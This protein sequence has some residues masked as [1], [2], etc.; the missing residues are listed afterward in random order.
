MSVQIY[1]NTIAIIGMA[2]RFPGNVYDA[3][4]L[5]DM[6]EHGRHGISHI[7]AERWPVDE[8][9]HPNRSEAGRSVTF[10]A[11]ALSNI[12]QFDASFFGISPREAAWLDPQQRLLLEMSYEAMEDAGVKPSSLAGSR[13][14]VY[15]GISALDYGQHALEDLASMSAYT[16]T[17]NTLSIA[18]NRLSYFFDLH[19]PSIAVDT[20]CSSS[21]VALHQA[22][23]ALRCGEVPVALAGGVNLLMH[24]YSFIGFSHASMLSAN[25]RCRPFDAA[26]DGYVRAEGGAMLLLKPLQQAQEDGDCIHAVILASGVNADGARKPGLTIPSTAAQA[27][28]M[29]DVLAR[30]GLDADDIAFIE[31][32]GTGT[33]VGDPIEAASIGLVYGQGRKSPMPISSVKANLGHMEPASGMAGLVKAI[34]T[35]QKGILPP[36]PLE[37]TPSPR[38]DFSGLNLACPASGMALHGKPGMLAA[39]VN[40]FGFGGVNAHVILR[41]ADSQPASSLDTTS[42]PPL[43]LSAHS[44]T[45]LRSLAAVYAAHLQTTGD[46]WYDIAHTAAFCRDR[47]EKRLIVHP[48]VSEDIVSTLRAFAE[49]KNSPSVQVESALPDESGIAFIYTGN[50]AQ[51][52][53]MGRN[54]HAESAVFKDVI[55]NLDQRMRPLLHFSLTDALLRDDVEDLADTT[56]SQPLLFAIQVGLTIL[57]REKGIR[58]QAVA[59]HSVG[60]IAAAWAAGA[61]T[62]D[63]AIQVIYARSYAQGQTRGGGR[64]AVASLSADAAQAL[65]QKKNL[66]GQLEIAGINAPNNVTLSGSPEA[67]LQ[68]AEYA[69]A[70]DVFFRQLDLDYAFHSSRMDAVHDV[71]LHKLEGLSPSRTTDAIF[72]SSVSGQALEGEALGSAYWWDNVRQPV[73]F[74]GAIEALAAF[75]FRIFVEIGPHAILQRYIRENLS[76]V[77]LK[78]RV[79]SSLLRG[80]DGAKRITQLA[81]RLH[82][83]TGKTD[84]HALFPHKGRRVRLPRY[85]WQKQRCWYPRTSE[86]QIDKRR[87]HPLLGWPLNG[88]GLSWENILDPAKDAWLNDHKVGEAVVFPGA[89]YVEVALAAARAWLGQKAALEYLDII[90]PLVLDGGQ[91]QS[92]RCSLNSDD[93]SISIVSRPRMGTGEWVQHARAR[94]IAL[95]QGQSPLPGCLLPQ[96]CKIPEDCREMTGADLYALT[97]QLGLDYGPTF[98]VVQHIRT[99]GSRLEA[100]VLPVEEQGYILPPALLDACFHS[101]AALYGKEQSAFLPIR[102]GRIE[103]HSS[104]SIS[105]IQGSVRRSGKRALSANFE[106]LD[107]DGNLVVRAYDCRFRAVPLA[108]AGKNSAESW[109]ICPWLVPMQDNESA[110]I[111]SLDALSEIAAQSTVPS[112]QREVWYKQILPLMEAMTLSAAVRAFQTLTDSSLPESCQTTPYFR[113]LHGL[114]R[115]EGVLSLHDGAWILS[116]KNTPPSLEE[117]WRE[118][119]QLA[120]QS[121][122]ALLPLGR[123]CRSLP[124]VL[125][126]KVDGKTLLEEIRHATVAGENRYL[127]SNWLGVDAALRGIMRHLAQSWPA[128]RRLRVLEVADYAADLPETLEEQLSPDRFDYALALPDAALS[129]AKARY[130]QHPAVSLMFLDAAQWHWAGQI[131]QQFDVVI[132]RHSLHKAH[133]CAGAL[134]QISDLLS[135]G[136]L[137]LLAERHPDWSTD[138]LEGLEP[139]WWRPALEDRPDQPVSSLLP[140][141]AWQHILASRGFADCRMWR[142]PAAGDLEE[143]AYLV[144]ARQT[145]MPAVA[146]VSSPSET[147][148]MCW[149]LLADEH[150]AALAEELRVRLEARGQSVRIAGEPDS[151]PAGETDHVVFMRGHEVSPLEVSAELESLRKCAVRCAESEPAPRL[152][153]MTRGGA[154]TTRLPEGYAPRPAQ[155]AMAGMARVVMNEYEALRCTLLDVPAPETSPDLPARLEQEFLRPDGNDEILLTPQA[156]YALRLQA[157]RKSPDMRPM[158]RCHLDFAVPGRLGNLRWQP[159]ATRPLAPGEIEARVTATGLNFRDV[160]LTMGL[161][162]DDAVENG[163]A[164]ANLGLEFAGIVT[165]TGAEADSVHIG[166]RIIGFAPAC[167]ASH[168]VTSAHTVARIPESWSDEAAA[169]IPTVFF[170]AW[171]ALKHLAQ[172]QSGES[173]LVHGAAGGVG[174][175]AIQIARFLGV[176]ILATAGSREKRDFLHLL[177]VEHVFDSRSLSF[178]DDVL[179]AT[180]GQG[181]DAVLNSLA[182]E[183]M[184]RSLGLLKPFGRFLE[185]GKRDFVEN[186]AMGLRPLKENISYFAI[187]V[188]QLLTAR[189]ETA[190][191][192]FQEVMRLLHAEVLRPLPYRA[193]TASRVVSA[194]RTMQQAQHMGKIVVTQEDLSAETPTSDDAKATDFSGAWLV[195]GGLSGFGL[196]TARHLA[197]CGVKHLVLAGRRGADTPEAREI[198]EYFR[199][200]DVHAV[201]AACDMGDATAVHALIDRITTS[202]P[203]LCG[204]VHA[205]AVFDDR[206][207]NKMDA[208]SL[209]AVLS[210]KFCGA[211][212]LHE[213][214]LH[215]PLKHFV[216]FS[217]ISVALGN[218]GQGNYVAANAGLEGLAHLRISMGLPALCIAWGPVGDAG[219]LTRHVSVKKS[220]TQHLGRE[221]LTSDE[222]MKSL[223]CALSESG[224]RIF[225][226]VDWRTVTRMFSGEDSRF[227][228]VASDTGQQESVESSVDIQR[229]LAGKEPQEA[230]Q[231]ICRLIAEEVAQV[232]GLD[233]SQVAQDR[234]VQSMGLDSLMAVELAVA[235]EQRMGVRLP[236]MMLQDSPSVEQIAERVLARLAGTAHS[237]GA[238]SAMLNELA[239]R[240][241]EDLTA[242]EV[243]DIIGEAR[244]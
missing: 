9:Q 165:R 48:D 237:D 176:T 7:P 223:D 76:A 183:A 200:Q 144:L 114:L 5:W 65:I 224:L 18:A 87:A 94:A 168:V 97:E 122:P 142:E 100:T 1:C 75:G 160:M 244:T 112:P 214:T 227:S 164:G 54:L 228:M 216:L 93:G 125:S 44:D 143:G 21:L 92:V 120:P 201:A 113:W 161:L 187:D 15:V 234:S 16:M 127:D 99:E 3:S 43:L 34:L 71:L 180:N 149:L 136:G 226:N 195:T 203:T 218:P 59:G 148:P 12:D 58:P 219:Y 123:V 210:P 241:A 191:T 204:I 197:Q 212:H 236:A 95:E 52:S 25:G 213:A 198:L 91:S 117:L 171:Y 109:N 67:L 70:R 116:D 90:T 39:A 37:F 222:A 38:I 14:G 193:F 108:H 85:P 207:L 81:A 62:L 225:A 162:P 89:G 6:L 20:A 137:V 199:K 184:R 153:I 11:G 189:P 68:V 194:F 238:D 72:V 96:G 29:G 61:L 211:W 84:A 221:P 220:L 121:L 2:F 175:A 124:D 17:G 235:L 129:Q 128:H 147:V 35:L 32:H 30:S 26:A 205:A 41:G 98:R 31:A 239:R 104:A 166:D 55:A 167:F 111:P 190:S 179:A 88:I 50:G 186:T 51:W 139:L 133:D 240:H 146:S 24:P 169:T 82:A 86:C 23:Q 42:V 45:A 181:V 209:H 215:L 159:D 132:L 28:L 217:S 66:S 155:Y 73:N 208:Q 177:G 102:T 107:A 49:G 242:N 47:L 135:P 188:D 119:F 36:M 151:L 150:S 56:V 63:E 79:F 27:E 156:R 130:G 134:E 101:L 69:Q 13:C 145:A 74:A 40:S 206:F 105:R 243:S 157:D 233:V 138:I 174:L 230:M 173:L 19:G 131:T 103:R 196:A 80:E 229:L 141:D 110:P 22:C 126:G 78:G 232:L 33:P 115:N 8:L 106:L 202:M 231:I 4:G 163:F 118:A 182:G 83:L 170:T 172:L 46:G 152:W 158:E 10:S 64:M 60:E 178:A 53:G 57:L 192:L 140:P 154:L 185:L 77:G